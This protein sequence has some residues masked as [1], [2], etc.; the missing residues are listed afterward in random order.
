MLANAA[1]LGYPN[2]YTPTTKRSLFM[3]QVQNATSSSDIAS[4]TP[5]SKA[6][7]N[8]STGWLLASAFTTSPCPST[9]MANIHGPLEWVSV[10]DMAMAAS[11]CV[12]LAKLTASAGKT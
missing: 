6:H 5:N 7:S 1:G 4:G 12:A 2:V 8:G 3:R 11:V 9:G 10:Q